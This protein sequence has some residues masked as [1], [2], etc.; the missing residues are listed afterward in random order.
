MEAAQL[1]SEP[2]TIAIAADHNGVEMKTRLIAVL[3]ELGY[4]VHDRGTNGSEIV[5]YPFLCADVGSQVSSGRADRGII[6]GGSGMG[7][8]IACNKLR[9]IR[10]GLCRTM[11]DVEI[12]RGNNNSNMLILGAKIIDNDVA[13]ELTK[14]WLTLPFKGGVH[15]QRIDQIAKMEDGKGLGLLPKG[16]ASTT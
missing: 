10:A 1:E 3:T 14:A 9:G 5:D 16:S 7:E 2:R 6:I 8:H 4:E 11:F 15:Q 13:A 12:S